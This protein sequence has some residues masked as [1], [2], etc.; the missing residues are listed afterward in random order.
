M[1]ILNKQRA[2]ENKRRER[3][4]PKE[5][6]NFNTQ[7]AMENLNTDREVQE[8]KNYV[9]KSSLP[10]NKKQVYIKQIER[11]G[12]NL[13]PIRKLV[14]QN[15]R[16]N[17][18]QSQLR[19]DILRVVTGFTGQYRRGWERAVDEAKTL[20]KLRDIGYDLTKKS[21]LRGE[22]EK[23]QI[24]PL[25]KRGHL[26]R[27][28]DIKDDVTKRRRIFEEQV[29]I[30]PLYNKSLVRPRNSLVNGFKVYNV[31]TTKLKNMETVPGT[32][33][34]KNLVPKTQNNVKKVELFERRS[35]TSTIN[36]LR[37][38]PV[39]NKTIF[40]GRIDRAKTKAEIIKI[41][42]DAKKMDDAIRE[43]ER[44][45]KNSIPKWKNEYNKR[46]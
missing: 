19:T 22:I 18:L 41:Q 29:K 26:S 37:K 36:R 27:V 4:K 8:L 42:A 13:K 12:T 34:L 24:G 35:A 46:L 15:V 2:G 45:K 23:S 20:P 43:E 9:K 10:E 11:P 33:S 1:N 5:E 14:N 38:L 40:K 31:P 30:N 25:K 32:K 3:A 17:K 21:I 39:K 44:R 28:M 7:K 6:N 16:M